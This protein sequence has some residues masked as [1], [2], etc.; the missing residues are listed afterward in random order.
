MLPDL[1]VSHSRPQIASD[2]LIH[3]KRIL[4]FSE[5]LW[6]LPYEQSRFDF[7]RSKTCVS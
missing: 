5:D 3:E 4:D 6:Q 1:A 2:G 7:I